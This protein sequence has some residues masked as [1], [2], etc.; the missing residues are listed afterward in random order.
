MPYIAIVSLGKTE[1]VY[2][3]MGS[4]SRVRSSKTTRTAEVSLFVVEDS[5]KFVEDKNR[6]TFLHV[7][8]DDVVKG[9]LFRGR[10]LATGN[11]YLTAARYMTW[12]F[13][14]VKTTVKSLCRPWGLQIAR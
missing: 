12:H 10:R 6:M 1:L 7:T 2:F 4:S 11:F 5:S 8:L 14:R 9:S 13:Y 3:V